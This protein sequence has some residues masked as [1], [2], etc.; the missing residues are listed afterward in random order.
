MLL[1]SARGRTSGEHPRDLVHA[2]PAHRIGEEWITIRG[3]DENAN[4]SVELARWTLTVL[5]TVLH[6]QAIRETANG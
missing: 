5:L 4:A 6:D 1:R 3:D 2:R